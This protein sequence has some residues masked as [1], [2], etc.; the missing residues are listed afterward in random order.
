MTHNDNLGLRR[1]KIVGT[2]AILAIYAGLAVSAYTA[3]QKQKTETLT[4]SVSPQIVLVQQGDNVI[5]TI[6]LPHGVT[7]QIW[8]DNSCG[9]PKNNAMTFTSSGSFTIPIQSI[10]GHGERF[11][12]VLSSDG[13]LRTSISLRDASPTTITAL[14]SSLNPAT[15][16]QSVTFTATVTASDGGVTPPTGTVT[17]NDGTAALGSNTLNASGIAT[18]S[19]STLSAGV[20]S[21]VATYA[22]GNFPGS[23]STTLTQT[24]NVKPTTTVVASSMN[25]SFFGQSVTFTATVS[26]SGGTPAGTVTFKDGNTTLGT[27]SLNGSGTATFSSTSLPLGAHTITAAYAGGGNFAG[28]TSNSLTQNVN[29]SATAT[30]LT[31]SVNPSFF[32]Q[33]VTFAATVTATGGGAGTPTGT[34]TF[35]D[36]ATVLGTG[37]LNGS[38]I[39]SFATTTLSVATHSVTA[40]YGGV[41]NYAASTSSAL[42]QTVKQALTTSAVKSSLNPSVTGKSVTFTATVSVTGGGAGTPTGS[43]TFKDGATTLQTQSLNSSGVATFTTSTL[44]VGSHSITVV[45]AATANFAGSTSAVLTQSV[46][47]H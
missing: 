21:I 34:V 4:L 26:G 9:S 41:A 23:T 44:S 35:K 5:L 37:T 25:P 40:V 1:S 28:S 10:K 3:P 47:A 43:V 13:L 42:S 2:L 33:S 14:Q 45:Y 46:T 39:A 24:V 12:C 30:A 29:Q 20:H 16:G 8:A 19:T 15:A 38:G 6:R 22:S 18:L 17:F 11:A 31:S 36:G 32:G 27:Q 7:A